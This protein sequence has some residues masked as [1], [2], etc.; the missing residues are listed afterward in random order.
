MQSFVPRSLEGKAKAE[1]IISK[2]PF[3]HVTNQYVELFQGKNHFQKEAF[4][5]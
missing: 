4:F 5:H 3:Q 2:T 1:V